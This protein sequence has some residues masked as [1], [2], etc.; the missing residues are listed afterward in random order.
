MALA[1]HATASGQARADRLQAVDWLPLAGYVADAG[2]KQGSDTSGI[3]TQSPK[4][5]N[6]QAPSA[7]CRARNQQC[8]T[9][10]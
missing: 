9:K 5:S 8:S 7:A 2:T 6:Q 3:G 10:F 1:E 4:G